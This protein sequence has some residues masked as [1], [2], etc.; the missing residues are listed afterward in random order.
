MHIFETHQP[1][2]TTKKFAKK[3]TG[4]KY[5]S[6]RSKF[7]LY[8]GDLRK[9]ERYFNFHTLCVDSGWQGKRNLQ[10]CQILYIK[11]N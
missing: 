5:R 11:M 10:T 4:Q 7:K 6:K 3:K 1:R 8:D 9:K 2:E